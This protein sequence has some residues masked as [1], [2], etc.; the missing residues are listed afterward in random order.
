MS[1]DGAYL[2]YTRGFRNSSLWRVR[3]SGGGE[4]E[5]IGSIVQRGFALGSRG[6]FFIAP[7]PPDREEL[8]Y[9]DLAAETVQPLCSF[10]RKAIPPISYD[11]KFLYWS[12]FDAITSNLMMV[13]H[14]Q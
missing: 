13:E 3:P 14:F 9:R 4:T 11:G 2:Y 10:R 1:N 5:V 6:V 12:Q 8:R 7:L